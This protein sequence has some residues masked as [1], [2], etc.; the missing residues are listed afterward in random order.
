MDQ[1]LFY[2]GLLPIRSKYES[3]GKI[4]ILI[5]FSTKYEYFKV[6]SHKLIQIKYDYKTFNEQFENDLHLS[7]LYRRAVI[8]KLVIWT[9]GR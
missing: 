2:I 9:K 7:A 3:Y 1:L 5:I 8:E 6:Y 4:L